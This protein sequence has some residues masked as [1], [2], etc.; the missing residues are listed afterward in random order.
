ME[1]IKAFL[2]WFGLMCCSAAN[3]LFYHVGQEVDYVKFLM[4]FPCVG[5]IYLLY[6]HRKVTKDW[7]P[8]HDPW[9][10]YRFPIFGLTLFLSLCALMLLWLVHKDGS[11]TM[12]GLIT[13]AIASFIAFLREKDYTE[14][15]YSG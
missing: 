6:I 5:V 1:N 15:I 10:G 2:I 8:H 13:I 12:V 14:D 9:S 3:G 7:T 11:S 4:I